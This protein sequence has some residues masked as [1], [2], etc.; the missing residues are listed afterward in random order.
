ML[1][2]TLSKLSNN[3]RVEDVAHANVLASRLVTACETGIAWWDQKGG[4]KIPSED[5]FYKTLQSLL[6]LAVISRAGGGDRLVTITDKE[7]RV[8]AVHWPAIP[9]T[10]IS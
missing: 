6:D 1:Q 10:T 9:P 2:T 3:R 5:I 7:A 8:L 4:P